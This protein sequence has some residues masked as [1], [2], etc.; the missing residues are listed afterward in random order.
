MKRKGKG[1]GANPLQQKVAAA[2]LQCLTNGKT[3]ISRKEIKDAIA[4]A[5]DMSVSK[6][7]PYHVSIPLGKLLKAKLLLKRDF[8]TF[9]ANLPAL[10]AVAGGDS[11]DVR[12]APEAKGPERPAVAGS[13]GTR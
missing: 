5:R 2:I 12:G 8:H 11:T 4:K 6:L 3:E 10:K 9:T 1:A 13:S 7:Q